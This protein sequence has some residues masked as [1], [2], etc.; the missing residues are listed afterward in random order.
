MRRQRT[1]TTSASPPPR[2]ARS[3]A[4]RNCLGRFR[5]CSR[6]T[7]RCRA[8]PLDCCPSSISST[9]TVTWPGMV[10]MVAER[11]IYQGE[12]LTFRYVAAP[13]SV[14]LV[15]YGIA[16][17]GGN[18]HNLAG[19]E[20]F[21]DDVA[22]IC[23]E[24]WRVLQ[25]WGWDGHTPLLF[26][27]PDGLSSR[28]PLRRFAQLLAS[29]DQEELAAA[30]AVRRG[31]RS[32]QPATPPAAVQLLISWLLRARA[33]MRLPDLVKDEKDCPLSAAVA[34][35]VAGERDVLEDCLQQ[36]EQELLL[37]ELR[38]EKSERAIGGYHGSP[39]LS[40][41]R[42]AMRSVGASN[43]AE[44]FRREALRF[45][46]SSPA[47]GA[48]LL[49]LSFSFGAVLSAEGDEL[50]LNFAGTGQQYWAVIVQAGHGYKILY[51]IHPL[52]RRPPSGRADHGVAP[53]DE[54]LQLRL[55]A[56][57]E[58]LLRLAQQHHSDWCNGVQS[59]FRS[60]Q[61]LCEELVPDA[62]E[63]VKLST[64][65]SRW[66]EPS[67][68]H[69]S[70]R[71]SLAVVPSLRPCSP[72]ERADPAP[73]HP[74]PRGRR[75][76]KD[77]FPEPARLQH[78]EDPGLMH[79]PP[80]PPE[81]L[82]IFLSA[83]CIPA[84]RGA[85]GAKGFQLVGWIEPPADSQEPLAL[86][87]A[88]HGL[89]L[90]VQHRRRDGHVPKRRWDDEKSGFDRHLD[91]AAGV[92]VTLNFCVMCAQLEW[93]GQGLGLVLGTLDETYDVQAVQSLRWVEH[94]I[95]LVFFIELL[96]R[97]FVDRREFFFHIANWFDT[98]LVLN[99]VVDLI[100]FSMDPPPDHTLVMVVRTISALRSIRIMRTMRFFQGLRL[101][102]KACHAFLPTLGWSMVVLGLMMS[103]SGLVVGQLLQY[104][105]AEEGEV[106][107]AGS[108]DR[109]CTGRAGAGTRAKPP[110]QP[111][112]AAVGSKR[113]TAPVSS[114][115]DRIFV[116]ERYG[117]AYRSIYT[118]YEP[119]NWP[120]NV[121]PVLDKVSHYYVIFFVLYI[122]VVVFAAIRVITAVFLKDTLDAAQNDA[123]H[124]LSESLKKKAQY[125]QKLETRFFSHIDDSRLAAGTPLERS[126][127]NGMITEER[128]NAMLELPSP[129]TFKGPEGRW[130]SKLEFAKQARIMMG[131]RCGA[132]DF[133]RASVP[134]NESEMSHRWP[135][136][137]NPRVKAYFDTL[138]L[139]VHEGGPKTG[140]RRAGS[141]G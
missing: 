38:V 115:E 103:I 86:L 52:T 87:F 53:M 31:R 17:E 23:R 138:D 66:E 63:A 90:G 26:T 85:R 25:S 5:W 24:K 122:T 128:L 91:Y 73:P 133:R 60:V 18:R 107:E 94:G 113:P 100:V 68:S 45:L 13:D 2:D 130:V 109:R 69:A 123:E 93:T 76:A 79:I 58:D 48:R 72:D 35:V 30:T 11:S 80:L 20:V 127:G 117:T 92:L 98:F 102:L 55:R 59:T 137:R 132:S 126:G 112:K 46:E 62:S 131:I 7:S 111:V 9:T 106:L 16:P 99:S 88:E 114:A 65:R 15:Q 37:W 40:C 34:A 42:W 27:V 56:A 8:R 57:R 51:E 135:T 77:A 29:V 44:D 43:P 4:R 12:E 71:W 139:A 39:W 89:C 141:G 110:S 14:L 47:E 140:E 116:W 95:S 125:V 74:S 119:W 81:V 22:K 78:A 33:R 108:C 6:G 124:Q 96:L 121:R 97:V 105:I 50:Q 75:E 54:R 10:A 67:L 134:R 129:A 41:D 32:A 82:Q 104:F 61:E 64:E 1:A 120:T 101:L 19:V 49:F 70:R 28:A 118:L 84:E 36:L 3:T 136:E 21:H 83:Q